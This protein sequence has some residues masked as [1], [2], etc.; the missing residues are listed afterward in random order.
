[1]FGALSFPLK[2]TATFHT[3]QQQLGNTALIEQP[4]HYEGL[5]YQA[6][7]YTDTTYV[8]FQTDEFGGMDRRLL[9]FLLS[10]QRPEGAWG[11]QCQRIQGP[12]S[13]QIHTDNGLYLGMKLAD[14]TMIMGVV[15]SVAGSTY[16]FE[17]DQHVT[18]DPKFPEG[19]DILGTLN[20]TVENDQVVALKAWY[21]AIS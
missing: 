5:C 1:V 4:E 18:T 12:P 13:S 6:V 7:S 14:L 2:S 8:V 20:V 9:G 10:R 16:T 17:Y 15:D 3:I 11:S 19:Y 21:V